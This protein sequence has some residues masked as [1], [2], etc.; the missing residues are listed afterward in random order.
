MCKRRDTENG[1]DLGDKLDKMLPSPLFFVADIHLTD[2]S[3]LLNQSALGIAPRALNK[4]A[5]HATAHH[6]FPPGT[7][8]PPSSALL[9]CDLRLR[10]CAESWRVLQCLKL[11]AIP[12]SPWAT[13]FAEQPKPCP[14]LVF[15]LLSDL[16]S[17]H[18]ARRPRLVFCYPR[19]SHIAQTS[20][21]FE[22]LIRLPSSAALPVKSWARAILPPQASL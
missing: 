8:P 7:A 5:E 18:L 11:S 3:R 19:S 2:S 20:L 12:H 4:G 17:F 15:A 6:P 10:E 22:F 13:R 14:P 21:T 16:V 9:G 1:T